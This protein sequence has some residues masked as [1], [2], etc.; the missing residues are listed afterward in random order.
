[1]T[2]FEPL[3]G[4]S[5]YNMITQM[6]VTDL[7]TL[8]NSR[9]LGESRDLTHAVKN[10]VSLHIAQQGFKQAG[11]LLI[12]CTDE[13]VE[14]VAPPEHQDVG[15]E[16][17]ASLEIYVHPDIKAYLEPMT[18]ADNPDDLL[19]F[20]RS[21]ISFYSNVHERTMLG[22]TFRLVTPAMDSRKVSFRPF[23]GELVQPQSAAST[24]KKRRKA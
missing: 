9:D 8:K 14:A 3:P 13:K 16:D 7:Q 11:N 5:Q 10:V 24:R 23:F 17:L 19:G 12:A 2:T 15:D 22:T 6:G 20:W 4:S 21:A 18:S 1:M